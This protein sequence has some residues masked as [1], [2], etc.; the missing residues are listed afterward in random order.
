MSALD[1]DDD[2]EAA[3]IRKFQNEQQEKL[4]LAAKIR[5]RMQRLIRVEQKIREFDVDHLQKDQ[6][7]E[8][9]NLMGAVNSEWETLK[10]SLEQKFKFC[11]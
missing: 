10:D 6:I 2:S 7:E 8:L 3:L 1:D 5:D 9:N 11:R 4:W